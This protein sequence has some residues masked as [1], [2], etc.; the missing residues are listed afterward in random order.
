M[1]SALRFNSCTSNIPEPSSVFKSFFK[2]SVSIEALEAQIEENKK[3]REAEQKQ[4]E[5]LTAKQK[6][7]EMENISIPY[8]DTSSEEKPAIPEQ[9]EPE[10]KIKEEVALP[11]NNDSL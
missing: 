6:E 2:P 4:L 7:E 5:Q 11:T 8:T 9:N 3:L 1:P 10:T